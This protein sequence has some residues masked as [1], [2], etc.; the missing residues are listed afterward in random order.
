MVNDPVMFLHLLLHGYCRPAY[1]VLNP[2]VG[3]ELLGFCEIAV[4]LSIASKYRYV[5]TV[6]W[7]QLLEDQR[8]SVGFLAHS[9]AVPTRVCA[10]SA[11]SQR[12]ACF[13]RYLLI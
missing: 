9:I 11:R 8:P 2:E 1:Y 6:R 5:H 4:S 3:V 12:P 7:Q 13:V 10:T